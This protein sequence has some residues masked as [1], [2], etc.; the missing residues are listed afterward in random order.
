MMIISK[1]NAFLVY[2][3]STYTIHNNNNKKA[4]LIKLPFP[5]HT[6]QKKTTLPFSPPLYPTFFLGEK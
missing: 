1:A 2:P 4:W 6:T 5:T 3:P